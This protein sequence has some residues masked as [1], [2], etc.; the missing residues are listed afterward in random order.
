M[1]CKHKWGQGSY[2]YQTKPPRPVNIWERCKLCGERRERKPTLEEIRKIRP[3]ICEGNRHTKAVHRLWHTF[4]NALEK[5]KDKME[6]AEK[7]AKTHKDVKLVWCDDDVHASS[8]LVLVPH[9]DP[10]AKLK[11]SKS[12][13][14]EPYWGTSVKYFPQCTGEKPIT[15]FLYPNHLKGLIE[16]LTELQKRQ[17]K[18]NAPWERRIQRYLAKWKKEEAQKKRVKPVSQV[19]CVRPHSS[20]EPLA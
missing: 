13:C 8:F 14:S 11:L 18:L 3:E 20:E 7:F 12:T 5:A 1:T 15:F 17:D 9:V 4:C 2:S 10:K 6:A 19:R 16:A